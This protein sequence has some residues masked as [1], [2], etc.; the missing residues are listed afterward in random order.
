MR[1]LFRPEFESVGQTFELIRQGELEKIEDIGKAMPE[2]YFMKMRSSAGNSALDEAIA[3]RRPEIVKYLLRNNGADPNQDG[4][5]MPIIRAI[6]K[7]DIPMVSLLIEAGA[8]LEKVT[9]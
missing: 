5:E 4:R 3:A 8:D 2:G 9:R 7:R 1:A 6:Y